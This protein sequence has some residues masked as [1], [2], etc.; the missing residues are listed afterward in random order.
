MYSYSQHC[1]PTH[2]CLTPLGTSKLE[3]LGYNLVKV[4]RWSTQSF[5][6][7]TSTWQTDR[8]TRCHSKCRGNALRRAAVICT[9]VVV[10]VVVLVLVTRWPGS[11]EVVF[12]LTFARWC[13][14]RTPASSRRLFYTCVYYQT[15]T[16]F[17]VFYSHY[18]N[19][20]IN[21]CVHPSAD[22]RPSVRQ[23]IL[24]WP[25]SHS[26]WFVLHIVTSPIRH[27]SRGRKSVNRYPFTLWNSLPLSV[28][29][30]SLILNS[31]LRALEDRAVLQSLWNTV[32][33]GR[34]IRDSLG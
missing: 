9:L 24:R 7:N 26:D 11:C 8:K 5:G 33:R 20:S 18:V 14:S 2:F 25:A 4:A 3:Q 13:R 1:A 6:H 16:M 19:A 22:R 23:Y 12:S 32:R 29:D 28:N 31:A 15:E 10:D 34:R 17:K 21:S 30:R 27:K